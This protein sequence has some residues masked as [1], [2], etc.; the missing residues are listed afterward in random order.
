MT[1]RKS[2]PH[3]ADRPHEIAIAKA[4]TALSH[5]RRVAILDA[6]AE[7]SPRS[8]GFQD[9]LTRTGLSVSTLNHHLAPMQAAG[10]VVRRLRGPK[11]VFSAR[12][13][14]LNTAVVYMTNGP[15]PKN[16]LERRTPVRRKTNDT[17][18]S[19]LA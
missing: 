2:L 17:P 5:P 10:L 8:V 9:L 6:L 19:N 13:S 3:A 16:Q 1:N 18:S 14:A 7:S 4:M 11:A 15:A 12:R